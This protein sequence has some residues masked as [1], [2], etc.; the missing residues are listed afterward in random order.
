MPLNPNH[1]FYVDF[2]TATR[3]RYGYTEE[4]NKKVRIAVK[5]GAIIPKPDRDELKHVNR[6]KDKEIGEQ[7][8]DPLTVHL[9]TY[10]GEDFVKVYHEFQEFIRVKEER[11]EMLSF[12]TGKRWA[13]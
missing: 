7:D 9:K 6:T 12:G 13:K 11:E 3:I 4:D 1:N 10:T 2:R 5:S 8:T